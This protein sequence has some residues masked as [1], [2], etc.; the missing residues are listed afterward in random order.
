MLL[1]RVEHRILAITYVNNENGLCYFVAV[2]SQSGLFNR[3]LLTECRVYAVSA[4]C[5]SFL[6]AECFSILRPVY[7][8][9]I[10][11]TNTDIV[12]MPLT[13]AVFLKL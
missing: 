4:F 5:Q 8:A 2:H 10:P 6:R 12:V 3:R 1:M 7:L 13:A 11:Q 9:Y